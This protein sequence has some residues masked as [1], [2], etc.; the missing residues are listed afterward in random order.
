MAKE[1]QLERG[2]GVRNDPLPSPL[3]FPKPL[4]FTFPWPWLPV[5]SGAGLSPAPEGHLARFSQSRGIRRVDRPASFWL[6]YHR[7]HRFQGLCRSQRAHT[8]MDLRSCGLKAA[9]FRFYRV[10][11]K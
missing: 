2:L 11:F 3:S 4:L 1:K 6:V 10:N 8:S 9:L 7:R 5:A